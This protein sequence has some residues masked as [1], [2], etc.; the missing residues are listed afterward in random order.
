MSSFIMESAIFQEAKI[1]NKEPGKA[2]FR[3][4]VQSADDVNQNGRMYP[5]K[6]I[7]EGM[8]GCKSR[9]KRRSMLNELDH[10][11][12]SG[13]DNFDA[14]RQTTVSLKEVSHMILDYDWEGNNLV[15]EIQTT[16]TPNGRILL[17]LLRDNSG[18]GF[19]LRG[20]AELERNRDYNV[21]KGPL[22]IISFDCV[23]S[24]SH[25]NAVVKDFNEMTFESHM[26]IENTNMVC[27]NGRCFLSEYFDKLVETKV[28]KF[29][30]RW[31]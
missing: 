25:Q 20:L 21:V 31:V 13:N 29:F 9:M 7:D 3:S 26:L 17:G 1:I 4:V 28:I 22:T 15:A 27:V 16:Q 30:E 11:F 8:E 18:I 5:K 14:V 19:S 10:P 12:P 6:V 2:I 24:P 23:S